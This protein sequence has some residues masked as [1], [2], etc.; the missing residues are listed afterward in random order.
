MLALL[1][2]VAIV[3][4]L[5]AGYPELWEIAVFVALMLQSALFVHEYGHLLAMR[6]FGHKDATLVLV[7][8]LGGTAINT[9]A[10]KSRF[11]DAVVAV[12]GPALSAAVAVA[13]VPVAAWGLRFFTTGWSAVA[14]D[15]SNPATLET[16]AGVCAIG[17]IAMSIA[18][19][20]YNLTPIGLLDGG[21][22]VFALARGRLAQAALAAAIFAALAYAFIGVAG[23]RDLGAALAFVATA[24]AVGQFAVKPPT[25]ALAPMTARERAV[26]L[27]AL[28]ATL[29]VFVG[30][31]RTLS[32]MLLAAL[33]EGAAPS[34]ARLD[35]AT[36]P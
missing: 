12:M 1:A 16:L 13:L 28:I 4:L 17:F 15:W 36:T 29:L 14:T 10:A 35:Q 31:S 30:A 20:L 9:R 27:A 26:V 11:E 22:I 24:W 18:I 5:S 32:P 21:R 6:W 25:D 34:V 3:A 8:L 19:N 7:P 2:F 33:Q 23:P